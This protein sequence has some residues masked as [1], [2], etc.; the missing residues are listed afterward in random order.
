[1]G[2]LGIGLLLPRNVGAGT[3]FTSSGTLSKHAGTI[4]IIL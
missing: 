4:D 2:L 3:M 1:M